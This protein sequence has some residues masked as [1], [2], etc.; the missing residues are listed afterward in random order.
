MAEATVCPPGNASFDTVLAVFDGSTLCPAPLEIAC[1]DDTCLLKS[2]VLFQAT[3][4][5]AYLI[6]VGGF[7]GNQGTFSL[8]LACHPPPLGD[9][10]AGAIPL[11]IGSNGPFSNQFA[12]HGSPPASACPAGFADLWFTFAPPCSGAYRIET[13]GGY[14]TILSVR[15]GCGGA[16]LG[17]NHDAA[18]GCAPGSSVPLHLAAGTI[19]IVRVAGATQAHGG[20]S[21]AIT[22]LFEVSFDSL[23]GPGSVGF[24]VR[25]AY[26]G[27][28]YFNAITLN[29]GTFPNGPFY[30]LDMTSAEVQGELDL[31]YPFVGLLDG[32]GDST[33]A[34]VPAPF[35][36]GVTLYSV[37]LAVDPTLVL[38][39]LIT[40]PASYTI[41]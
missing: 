29:L 18:P 12:T 5:S 22:R 9:H 15:T 17:C 41:P 19:S 1:D 13:C 7:A 36:S 16:E 35:L 24:T 6:A 4:G 34:T 14:D 20:F 3:A 10:C 27:G 37:G 21:V 39:T 23:L 30:G 26:P 25:G 2:R 40:P 11:A 31:G 38:P 32:C 33:F 8:A 28:T